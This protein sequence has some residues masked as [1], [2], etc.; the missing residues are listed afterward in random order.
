MIYLRPFAFF[1]ALLIFSLGAGAQ[2]PTLNPMIPDEE[3]LVYTRSVGDKKESIE[4]R[5][6]LKKA[7]E[8]AYYELKSVSPGSE[9][10]YR[11]DASTLVAT[12]SDVTT[13]KPDSKVRRTMQVLESKPRLKPDELLLSDFESFGQTLRGFPWGQ[14]QK[15]KLVFMGNEGGGMFSLELTV[16]GKETITAGGRSYECWK[17]QVGLGGILGAAFAKTSLWYAIAEPHVLVRSEGPQG[18]PG[19]PTALTELESYSSSARPGSAALP[20][21]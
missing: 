14:R 17:A 6:A 20:T 15:A 5:L 10:T 13:T 1:G 8:G 9:A 18:P 21:R 16:S 4:Y 2:V 3:T 7:K 12:Y 19:S 11:L